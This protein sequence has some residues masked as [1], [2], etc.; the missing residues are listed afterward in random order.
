MNTLPLSFRSLSP[1]YPHNRVFNMRHIVALVVTLVASSSAALADDHAKCSTHKGLSVMYEPGFEPPVVE[2]NGLIQPNFVLL[3]GPWPETASSGAVEPGESFTITYSFVPDGTIIPGTGANEQDAPS[4]LFATM[5]AN[6][7]GGRFAWQSVFHQVFA[8]YGE[9]TNINFVFVPDDGASFGISFPF[10][11]PSPG[12]PGEIGARGDMRISMRPI[13]AGPL[14]RNYAPT[15]GG[16]MTMDSLDVNQFSDPTNNFRKLRN[17]LFHEIGHGLGLDHVL[18]QNATKLM[19]PVLNTAFDGPQEDDLRAI[20]YLYGDRFESNE[21]GNDYKFLGLQLQHPSVNGT[22]TLVVEDLALER[23]DS[24]DWYGVT[25]A[26]SIDGLPGVAIRV[27]PVG[28]QYQYSPD[29]DGAQMQTIDAAAARDLKFE[30]YRR[31]TASPM[32]MQLI[33]TIDFNAAGEAEYRPPAVYSLGGLFFIRVFSEDGIDDV[34]RYRLTVSNAEIAATEPDPSM[35]LSN[36]TQPIPSGSIVDMPTTE[37]G[38]NGG[39]SLTISNTGQGMLEI[40]GFTIV[41]PAGS[42]YSAFLPSQPIQPGGFGVLSIGF[43][44]TAAGFRAA[45]LTISTNDPAGDYELTLRATAT[46]PQVGALTASVE[47]VTVANGATFDLGELELGSEYEVSVD[48]ENVGNANMSVFN[49]TF[50]NE[51]TADF[52]QLTDLP[53][54]LN[55]GATDTIE[56]LVKPLSEGQKHTTMRMSNNGVQ[57]TYDVV[58]SY[59]VVAVELFDDCNSNGVDDATELDS[60]G[61]GIID[62]CEVVTPPV[63]E[64]PIVVDDPG[65]DDVDNGGNNE[66]DDNDNIDDD[67]IDQD[68]VDN[69]GDDNNAN[70]NIIDQNDD[71]DDLDNDN[72]DDD[73]DENREEKRSGFCG[74]GSIGMLTLTMLGLSGTRVR[75]RRYVA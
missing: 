32:T 1:L 25:V 22:Q 40:D 46:E 59:S 23:E 70:D 31:V 38:Q 45:Q 5:D 18:P 64:D 35:L 13:G 50:L 42:D 4:N 71:N 11:I 44:P 74:A 28:T 12:S 62:D 8:R 68:I 30:L 56:L 55:T 19:E 39:L 7:P 47:G 43:A 66:V 65:N 52:E 20:H 53:L 14:A 10:G 27:E 15:F 41:G 63:D 2:D 61:N 48:L 67:G 69:D 17:V 54:A 9:M 33:S 36:A 24:E 6:F 51:D 49:T 72:Q 57:P 73:R 75:R 60:D 26:G 34:Q 58:F 37:V 21:N 29:E 3:S 16:D